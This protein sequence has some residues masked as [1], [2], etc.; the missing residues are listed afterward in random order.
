MSLVYQ[1][2]EL[3]Q[4]MR[5]RKRAGLSSGVI[6][7]HKGAEGSGSLTENHIW[8]NAMADDIEQRNAFDELMASRTENVQQENVFDDLMA[9]WTEKQRSR[10]VDDWK[11]DEGLVDFDS[12]PQEGL[13][14]KRRHADESETSMNSKL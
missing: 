2:D 11:N 1:Y 5:D 9:K 6:C 3:D 7:T 12:Q 14:M 13:G 4:R 10:F 8:T